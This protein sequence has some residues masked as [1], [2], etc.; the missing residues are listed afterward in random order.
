M[1]VSCNMVHDKFPTLHAHMEFSVLFL[2]DK[3][4]IS[5]L[6]HPR[7][8]TLPKKKTSKVGVVAGDFRRSVGRFPIEELEETHLSFTN[9]VQTILN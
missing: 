2:N 5:I 8:G 4:G 1:L 9:Y 6:E 3:L 7:L